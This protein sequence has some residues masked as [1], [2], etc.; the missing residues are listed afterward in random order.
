MI[1]GWKKASKDKI[2]DLRQTFVSFNVFISFRKKT[3][4]GT[5]QPER[6]PNRTASPQNQSHQTGQI[7]N[8]HL[9]H[10]FWRQRPPLW[11]ERSQTSTEVQRRFN[12]AL[13]R[14][15]LAT[16]DATSSHQRLG[17]FT[18]GWLGRFPPSSCSTQ[19][20]G[21]CSP[22]MFSPGARA[23]SR[24]PK[25]CS[26]SSMS[27]QGTYLRT[28]P[29]TCHSRVSPHLFPGAEMFAGAWAWTPMGRCMKPLPPSVA[30]PLL[31]LPKEILDPQKRIE[32]LPLLIHTPKLCCPSSL[33]HPNRINWAT[34]A[35]PV[36][37]VTASLVWPALAC[38]LL[39]SWGPKT[40]SFSAATAAPLTAPTCR[41]CRD[42]AWARWRP[43][44]FPRR[45]PVCLF[46]ETRRRFRSDA[47]L[48]RP[49]RRSV[50]SGGSEIALLSIKAGAGPTAASLKGSQ[51]VYFINLPSL[52][53]LF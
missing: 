15:M 30:T 14:T 17:P 40:W 19:Q 26:V 22:E 36:P 24:W 50:G 4:I 42:S 20:K 44:T 27:R 12:T 37:S 9:K 25:A 29:K 31:N 39:R 3:F 16:T 47:A 5:N 1:C 53:S 23:P 51:V 28:E 52:I 41:G 43:W 34:R 32:T 6:G 11:R 7:Q 45:R 10:L 35:S 18:L 13:R 21:L 49:S 8:T 38:R 46:L 2:T 33:K 48:T